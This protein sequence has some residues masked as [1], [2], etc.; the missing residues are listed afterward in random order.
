MAL[1]PAM[2]AMAC[3]VSEYSMRPAAKRMI[4]L[5]EE[6]PTTPQSACVRKS[7]AEKGKD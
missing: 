7:A 5:R 2:N 1:A 6:G 3:S 4:E